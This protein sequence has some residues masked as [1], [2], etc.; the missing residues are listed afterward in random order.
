MIDFTHIARHTLQ[1]QPYAWAQIDDLFSPENAAALAATFPHDHFK[2]V[3]GYGGEKDYEYEARALIDMERH[4]IQYPEEL[5][6]AWLNLARDFLSPSYRSAMSAL[7]D[8]DLMTA[9]LEVNVF[10]YGPGACLGPHPD[11]PDKLVT[12][13][14]YFNQAW[15]RRDG[16]CL[17]I[18]QNGDAASVVAEIEP[19]VGNST[20]LVR[21]E[22]SWHAV[23]R[24]VNSSRR[25]RR[26]LT[27]TFYRPGSISSMWPSRD[28]TPL[29]RYD[30]T[31]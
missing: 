22:K 1:T 17:T 18:L 29:R 21:S 23:S 25:S 3:A 7:T 15:D 28:S 12:H 6:T 27:A 14:L 9:P 30:Q 8:C 4:A 26:S 24:V 31:D 16:G 19:L 5:S 20:V 2:T 13:I 11:L 10:H